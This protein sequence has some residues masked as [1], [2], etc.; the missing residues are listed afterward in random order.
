M[1]SQAQRMAVFAALA[2][3]GMVGLYFK[4]DYSGWVVFIGVVGAVAT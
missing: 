4:V 2:I 1:D 3:A